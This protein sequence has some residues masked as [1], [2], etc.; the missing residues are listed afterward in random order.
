VDVAVS[1]KLVAEI[2]GSGHVTYSGDPTV[3]MDVSGSGD[4]VQD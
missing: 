3:D 2:S 4:V 1:E